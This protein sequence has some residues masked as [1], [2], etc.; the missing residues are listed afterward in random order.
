MRPL[1]R[2][3]LPIMLPLALLSAGVAAL[4]Q[5]ATGGRVENTATLSFRAAT[6]ETATVRSNTVSL[7]FSRSKRPTRISF[8]LAPPGRELT[9][10]RCDLT[11]SPQYT[12]APIDEAMLASA[13]PLAAFD[14]SQ[15]MIFVLDAPGANRDPAVRD[16]ANIGIST[17]SYKGEIPILETA[18]DSGVFAGGVP[19]VGTQ[20]ELKPCEFDPEAWR[21]REL[22][23]YRG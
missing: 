5:T 10:A 2:L 18:P 22:Q 21:A 13:P 19:Q 7:P 9:G 17:P 1:H 4:A 3:A 15:P 16:T 6:G 20:A 8:R 11:P 23:L 12:P 14:L